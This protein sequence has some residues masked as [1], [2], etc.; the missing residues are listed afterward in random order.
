M[1][2][3]SRW[4]AL[5]S[6]VLAVAGATAAAA[7]TLHPST[8][9][10]PASTPVAAAVTPAEPSSLTGKTLR[11]GFNGEIPGWSFP[12]K[13]PKGFDVDLANYLAQQLGF[14][15]VPVALTPYERE[16]ALV[17]GKVDLVIANYSMDGVSTT[18]KTK[19][20][21][22]VI[23][24]AGPYFVDRSG[25][26]I[27]DKKLNDMTG[28]TALIDPR[29][30]CVTRGTTAEDKLGARAKDTLQECLHPFFDPADRQFAA[31]QTDEA[32]LLSVAQYEKASVTDAR[33]QNG[34]LINPTEHYGVGLRKGDRDTCVE[35]TGKIQE[36]VRSKVWETSYEALHIPATIQHRPIGNEPS[37][38]Y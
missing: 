5:S 19:A 7:I 1:R 29:H 28:Q 17:S 30:I 9:A 12:A 2:K 18:D 25:Q 38:C 33:W 22:D 10:P 23:D 35:L 34:S 32:I 16:G 31:V 27:D 3:R 4:L 6:A 20:R 13:Q 24:F 11:V 26:M 14:T 8:D 15:V 36:F 37:Y 21:K